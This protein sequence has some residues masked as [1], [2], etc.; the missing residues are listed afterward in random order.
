MMN[1]RVIRANE[2]VYLRLCT[3]RDS[4]CWRAETRRLDKGLYDDDDHTQYMYYGLQV[5]QLGI[6][7]CDLEVDPNPVSSYDSTV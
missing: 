1:P 7:A 4:C 6:R 3:V 5:I 2:Q